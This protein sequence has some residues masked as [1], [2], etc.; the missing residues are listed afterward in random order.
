MYQMVT[1]QVHTEVRHCA[2]ELKVVPSWTYVRKSKM[3]RRDGLKNS[4]LLHLLPLPLGDV[5]KICHGHEQDM[6]ELNLEL[7]PSLLLAAFSQIQL[8]FV[9]R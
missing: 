7:S 5:S 1:L 8:S 3:P 9:M 4:N 2:V 6:T